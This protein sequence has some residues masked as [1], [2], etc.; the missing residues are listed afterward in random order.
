MRLRPEVTLAPGGCGEDLEIATRFGVRLAAARD[1][2]Q[3]QLVRSTET[4]ALHAP[5]GLGGYQVAADVA[6]GPMARRIRTT[7]RTDPLPRAF[8]LHRRPGGR[9]V[10]ATA[11][12]GRDALVLASLGCDVI[13]VERIPALCVLLESATR[14]LGIAIE[15]VCADAEVWLAALPR[16]HRP[17]AVYLDPMFAEQGKAQVKKDMQACR[18]LAGPPADTAPLLAAARA[19]ATERVVVK[20]HPSHPPLAAGVAHAVEAARVRFDVYLT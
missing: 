2:D 13:A 9:I 20:R 10:D 4:V 6:N 3:W 5:Q 11:G 14:A 1:P 16:K 12:L 18:E 17:R 7:R 8:G 19:V 15:V